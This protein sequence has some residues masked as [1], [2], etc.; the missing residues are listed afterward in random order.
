[1]R[2]RWTDAAIGHLLAIYEHIFKDSPMYASR[3]IDRL[4]SRS[5]QIADYPLS[6]RVVP[7]HQSQELREVI[8]SPYR[9]IYL[10]AADRLEVLAVIHSRQA[11][12][13]DE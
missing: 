11:F 9:I 1:M 7:E 4:L 13:L 10:V 2:V 6:G 5:E 8:E 3:V 12:L